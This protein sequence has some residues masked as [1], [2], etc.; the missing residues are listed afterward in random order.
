MLGM[1][2][3]IIFK[4]S[5]FYETDY[6]GDKGKKAPAATSDATGKSEASSGGSGE[7]GAVSTPS[8]TES[9]TTKSSDS[10]KAK[11]E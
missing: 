2:S 10:G 1:G 9:S 8:K 11:S 5:G 4:G 7:G 3:G 6:K